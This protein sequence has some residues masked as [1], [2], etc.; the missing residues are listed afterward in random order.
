[1]GYTIKNT[2]LLGIVIVMTAIIGFTP[3]LQSSGILFLFI[4]FLSLYMFLLYYRNLN[5]GTTFPLIANVFFYVILIYLYRALNISDI[6]WGQTIYKTLFFIPILLM[7]FVS[8]LSLKQSKWLILM[9]LA[10]VVVDILDNIRL[11]LLHPDIFLAVNRDFMV[12]EIEGVGNIGGSAWYNSICF[13]FLVCFFGFLNCKKKGIRYAML[14]SSLVS[15]LFVIV[16]CLKASVIVFTIM[17]AIILVFAKKTKSIS[18][19]LFIGILIAIFS[20]LFI[21]LFADVI[22]DFL[23]SVAEERL[24]S[25]MMVFIDPES[26]EANSG[27]STMNARGHLWMVSINTWLSNPVNFLFGI[28]DHHDTF[29][30]E[31][32]GIGN[33]SDLFDTF[34]RY[35]LFGVLLIF[36]ILRLSSKYVLSLYSK[37]YRLQIL[38]IVMILILFGFTKGI[39]K[40][41][42][43]CSLFLILPLLSNIIMEEDNNLH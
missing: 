37:K 11:C 14:L 7:P 43:G 39:F 27:V 41:A 10:V 22:T 25:R 29:N 2:Q 36:N 13:F 9:V 26:M 18:R 33:H 8:S 5:F 38:N 4:E 24:A 21:V 35:G 34:G 28:G 16:F 32:T 23:F 15:G 19:F 1:M 42:I 31:K 17:S 3:I 6:N 12:E 30:P 40:Y 20:Y